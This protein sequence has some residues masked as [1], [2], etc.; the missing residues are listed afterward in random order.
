MSAAANPTAASPAQS[1]PA[2]VRPPEYEFHPLANIFPEGTAYTALVEDIKKNGLREKIKLY[3]GKILDGRNRYRACKESYRHQPEFEELPHGTN[4]LA[5]VISAN[6]HRR[7]L[8]ETQR[9]IVAAKIANM[10]RGGKEANS[11]IDGIANISQA[12]AA[13]LLNVS[14]KTVERASKLV[15]SGIPELVTKAEQGKVKVSAAVNFVEKPEQERQK[16]LADKAGDIV[17]AVNAA[18][19]TNVSEAYHRAQTAL[20]GKLVLMNADTAEAS[21]QKTIEEL[22]KTVKTKNGGKHNLKLV[23]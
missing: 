5:F 16:L 17:K 1:A 13:K 15:G 10:R 21:A 20:I 22:V 14:P 6:L 8:N 7:H 18:T 12:D 3:D 2:Q 9:G 4:P 19:G 11:S 23:A